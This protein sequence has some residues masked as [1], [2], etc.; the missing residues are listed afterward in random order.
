MRTHLTPPTPEGE[1]NGVREGG[2]D[3]AE[4]EEG[5]ILAG[6]ALTPSPPPDIRYHGNTAQGR[7]FKHIT[8]CIG[9]TV[10]MSVM[11]DG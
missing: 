7:E 1:M 4:E 6:G 3:E 9:W 10:V 11:Y 5:G 2:R 8:A